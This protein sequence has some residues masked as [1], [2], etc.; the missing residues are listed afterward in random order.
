MQNRRRFLMST[1][2]AV[3]GLACAVPT[4][5]AQCNENITW[6]ETVDVL[7]VGS[8]FSG[9][10]A[11]LN[12]NRKKVGRI[13]VLEKM[14]VIGGNSAVNGGW[15]AIPR[16]PIQLSQGITDDSPEDLVSDQV[17]SGRGMAGVENLRAIANHALPAYQMCI[18]AGVKF[19]DGFNIQVGGHNKARAI[20]TQHGTGG[21]ITTKLY[22]VSKKEGVEYRLQNYVEDF[23][24]EDGKLI[25]LKVRDGFRFPDMATGTVRYIRAT[26]GVV[27]A[28]GGFARNKELRAIFDP[29]LDP[30]LDCTNALGATGE[31]TMTAMSHGALTLHMNMIQTGHW[32]SPDEGGF[33]WSNA[34][35]SISLHEGMA[36]SVLTGQRF[37]DERQDRKYCSEKIMANRYS[38]G[39]P[40][41][42]IIFFSY[43]DHPDDDRVVRALRDKMAWKFDSIEEM[44]KKFNIDVVALT[45][46]INQFNQSVKDRNDPLLGR[47]MD[48]A[49]EL[50]APF[51][52][53]RMWPKVHYC[54]GGMKTDVGGRVIASTTLKPI[55]N[56]YA[57][58]EATGG[59]HGENRL[60]STS[61]LEGLAMGI[62]VSQT[63]VEDSQGG[64]A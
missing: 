30:T 51:V 54:M 14:Q 41:Y 15:L 9:L 45:A 48:T 6:D 42:P 23:I 12:L 13:L 49:R 50:K 5:S 8:G 40:A 53:S 27:L 29:A 64:Q 10:S 34:L 44:A 16:N 17:K 24:M 2:L 22:E 47:K 46:S 37:M 31:V 61:C 19:K 63:I 26:K 55:P 60:S 20:R 43:N 11:A 52:A 7:I 21:D 18:D 4:A 1:G 33:G 28:N 35:L 56:M 3:G 58:G 39:T 62:V 32:A 38:D 25:G 36:V 59:I 57:I